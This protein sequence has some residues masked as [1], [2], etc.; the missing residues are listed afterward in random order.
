MIFPENYAS[1]KGTPWGM[2]PIGWDANAE[3]LGHAAD[4]MR[5]ILD[6]HRG[7]PRYSQCRS[8]AR[9][10]IEAYQRGRRGSEARA[11]HIFDFA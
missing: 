5:T 10:V 3:R 7:L 6:G 8:Y 11:E 4:E 9:R 2:F 1:I